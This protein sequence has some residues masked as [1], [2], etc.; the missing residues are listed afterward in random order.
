MR[1]HSSTHWSNASAVL[2]PADSPAADY[3]PAAR[4]ALQHFPLEVATLTPVSVSENITF[5]V[6]DVQ[7]SDYALRLHRPGYN[8]L[9]ELE[10]ERQWCASLAGTGLPLQ[11]PLRSR[12]G[13]HFVAVEIPSR[14]ERRYAG[15]TSWLPGV[16]LGQHLETVR[17][18][19][20]RAELFRAMGRLAATI[21]N[22]S[23]AWTPPPGFVRP[24]L[25]M[26]GLVGARPRWGRFWEHRAL[27]KDQQALLVE[28]RQHLRALLKAYGTPS[29][30]FGLI[31]ADLHPGNIVIAGD[32]MGLIDF[33]DCA[34]GWHLYDL[35]SALIEYSEEEDFAGLRWALLDGYR[36]RRV[37]SADDERLLPTFLLLRGMALIGWYHQR[38]EH[39]ETSFFHR[40]K[41]RVLLQSAQL[42]SAQGLT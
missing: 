9:H 41:E 35:A 12:E 23:E 14:A 30:V 16:L 40:V 27:D 13:V 34:F 22:R 6:T 32:R 15:M 25:D 11:R 18:G 28:T 3:L 24:R 31:H 33:D 19:R 5:R 21:H 8:S 4:V 42:L 20:A 10:S 2:M 36:E 39:A 17:A 37:L 1:R 29:R 26:G 7:G 38:P